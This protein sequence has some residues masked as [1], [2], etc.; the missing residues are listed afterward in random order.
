MK[1]SCT[2][3][4]GSGV[5]LTPLGSRANAAVCGC[6]RHCSLCRD[7]GRLFSKDAAHREFVRICECEQR[8]QR[9]RLYNEAGVP[10]KFFDARLRDEQK[11]RHNADA[12]NTFVLHAKDYSRND[13]GLVLMG[14]PG[15]GKTHLVAA[16][17][18]ELIFRHGMPTLFQDFFDL[19]SR[20]RSGYSRDEPEEALIAPLI[21]VDV[22]VVD[23]LGKGRNTPWE[24]TIL[25]TIISHR[26][27]DRKTTVFTTNFTESRRT[28]LAER[29]RSKDRMDEEREVRETLRDRVG[30]RIYSRLKEMCD[31]IVLEGP[32]RRDLDG[33]AAG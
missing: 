9:V 25:D 12:Y 14:A 20:L 29:V 7:S 30:S 3:C 6:S 26:Y 13:R 16:F 17:I 24:Q 8:R 1:R 15:T 4:D 22:L 2:T 21:Q 27:N 32:D 33:A 23:E 31:F 19:L 18:Y 5:V 28:T 10:A 11:D